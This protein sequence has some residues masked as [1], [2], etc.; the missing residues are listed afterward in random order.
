M[1]FERKVV[2]LET[3]L[4]NTF[5]LFLFQEKSFFLL[6]VGDSYGQH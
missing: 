5:T 3:T 1:L 6:G 4:S 2:V